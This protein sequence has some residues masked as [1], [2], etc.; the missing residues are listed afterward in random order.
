MIDL[1]LST[2]VLMWP[3]LVLG[4]LFVISRGFIRDLHAARRQGQDLI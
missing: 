3:A 1:L 2:Y 4:V